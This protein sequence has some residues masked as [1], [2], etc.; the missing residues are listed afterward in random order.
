MMFS[1]FIAMLKSNFNVEEQMNGDFLVEKNGKVVE[2]ARSETAD[3]NEFLGFFD[4]V[5][6]DI[7]DDDLYPTTKLDWPPKGDIKSP[8]GMTPG[9]GDPIFGAREPRKKEGIRLPPRARFDPYMPGKGRKRDFEPDPDHLR[10][11]GPDEDQW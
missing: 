10:K 7:G 11:P 3:Y 8:R 9:I 5:P 2:V 1:E 4:A 6:T